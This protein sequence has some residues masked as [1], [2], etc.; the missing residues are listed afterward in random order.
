MAKWNYYAS[1]VF[2]VYITPTGTYGW[3]NGSFDLDGWP[4][5]ADIQAVYGYSWGATTIG[6]TFLMYDGL[7]WI[8]EADIALNPAFS[9]T[10]DDE[11][12]LNGGSAQGFRQVMHHELGHMHGLEHQFNYL[13]VMN[14]MPSVFRFFAMPYADDAEGIRV[15]YPANAVSVT[16]LGIYLYYSSGYQSVTDATIPSSV[17]AGNSLTVNNYHLENVGTTT[18]TTPTVEWYLTSVRSFESTYYFLGD[19]TYSSLARFNYFT[20]SSVQRSFTVPPTVPAGSYYLAAYIRNDGGAAQSG[21]PFNNNYA[22]SRQPITVTSGVAPTITTPSPLTSGVVGTAYSQT[23]AATGGTTPYTW[24]VAAGTLPTGLALS[25]AGVLSGTPTVAATA[26]FTVKVTGAN[27]LF[28]TKV[29]SLTIGE[30]PT[31]TTPSPLPSGVKGTAYS[32]TLAA[33]GGTTPYAWTIAA[34]TLPAGLSLSTAGVLSGTPTAAVV[35]SFTVKVTGANSLFST[36]DFGLTIA[37]PPTITTP[38]PLTSGVVG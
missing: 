22:F 38:T 9:F 2:R 20:P 13:S 8:T 14:Y 1:E 31:I 19:S 18:I 32:Q 10:L 25:T 6:V 36:K 24:A 27:S 17:V 3:G 26:S 4:S 21:F 37:G 15:E 35:A 28:S 11:W 5:L 16:D 30:Q 34:G 29:F 12:V 33:T 23:F 7:G